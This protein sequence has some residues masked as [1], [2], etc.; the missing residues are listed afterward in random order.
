MDSGEIK[1]LKSYCI[2]SR[3]AVFK[4]WANL[5]LIISQGS[6]LLYNQ[7]S[8]DYDLNLNIYF[9]FYLQSPAPPEANSVEPASSKKQQS[10]TVPSCTVISDSLL[11]RLLVMVS[12]FKTFT[13]LSFEPVA[14]RSPF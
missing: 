6:F 13:T 5:G 8:K 7:F 10:R 3:K 14:K 2:E 9:N 12:Y 11:P 4:E 1:T